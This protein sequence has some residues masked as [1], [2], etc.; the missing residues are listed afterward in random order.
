MEN[1]FIGLQQWGNL[2][3]NPHPVRPENPG[4]KTTVLLSTFP[5]NPV[6]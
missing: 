5:R 3:G 2:Q 4:H 1:P 6:R